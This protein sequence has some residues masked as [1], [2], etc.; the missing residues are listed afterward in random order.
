LLCN[1]HHLR[2]LIAIVKNESQVWAQQ[3]KDLLLTIK[4]AVDKQ[5]DNATTHL[6]LGQLMDFDPATAASLPLGIWKTF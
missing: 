4:E 5:K 2:E 3:M 6:E 1:A